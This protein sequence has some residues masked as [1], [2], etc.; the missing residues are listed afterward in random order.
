MLRNPLASPDVLGITPRRQR[1]RGLR[2]RAC[3][4]AGAARRSPLAALAGAVVV[5]AALI[6]QP[7]RRSRRG[8]RPDGARRGRRSRPGC[9]AVVHWVLVR[10]EHLPRRRTRCVWLSGSLNS[11]DL[12]RRSP[13]CSSLDL[14]C[15]CPLLLVARPA[16]RACS[17]SATTSRPASGCACG[18]LRG[19]RDGSS[20][21][22]LVAVGHGRRRAR[23]PSSAFLSG[24]DRPRASCPGARRI[25]VGALVGA[26]D[27]ARPPTTSPPTPSPAPPCRSASSPACSV[28][29]SCSGCSAP[30]PTTRE[31]D[32]GMT[33]ARV[34]DDEPARGLASAQRMP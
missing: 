16:L 7:G 24:P 20:S 21:S 34:V 1:R 3:S 8:D 9:S 14:P 19:R 17:G 25:G 22:L 32:A 31:G 33:A 23:S 12:G 29:R 13:G 11:V 5:A 2:R 30:D 28:P 18:R 10:A 15:C 6:A 4:A 27:R 26:V